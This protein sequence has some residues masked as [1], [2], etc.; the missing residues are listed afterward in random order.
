[1]IPWLFLFA[2]S[3]LQEGAELCIMSIERFNAEKG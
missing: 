3:F 2:L 1:M